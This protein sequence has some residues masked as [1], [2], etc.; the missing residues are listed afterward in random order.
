LPAAPEQIDIAMP[1][2]FPFRVK[3][4]VRASRLSALFRSVY[5]ITSD[6]LGM[7]M[8]DK[9]MTWKLAP[10][11]WAWTC[12]GGLLDMDVIGRGEEFEPPKI[13]KRTKVNR[14]DPMPD[15]LLLDPLASGRAAGAVFQ[16]DVDAGDGDAAAAGGDGDDR[17]H[18]PEHVP[19]DGGDP[20]GHNADFDA[21]DGFS[22]GDLSDIAVVLADVAHGGCDVPDLGSIGPEAAA[23]VDRETDEEAEEAAPPAAAAAGDD[24]GLAPDIGVAATT[25][26]ELAARAEVSG[27][28]YVSVAEDM[29]WSEH[30]RHPG[31][32]TTWPKTK[33]VERRSVS[34]RCFFHGGCSVAKSRSRITDLRLLEWLFSAEVDMGAPAAEQHAMRARHKASFDDIFNRPADE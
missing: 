20:L 2:V 11:H 22:D 7:H 15:V 4:A 1:E 14:A 8:V 33:P 13:V 9:N 18:D 32:I 23:D 12:D 5:D 3:I 19:D 26:R 29:P 17:E 27:T 6:E 28:G 34:M 30:L 24:S 10:L 25:P 31:R 16:M 21:L